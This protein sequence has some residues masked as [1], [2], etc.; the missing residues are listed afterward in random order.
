MYTQVR[1]TKRPAHRSY[2]AFNLGD[3]LVEAGD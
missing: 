2:A 3:C 1:E